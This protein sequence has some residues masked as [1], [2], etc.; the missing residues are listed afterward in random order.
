M[1]RGEERDPPID[2]SVG[3]SPLRPV[4]ADERR[5]LGLGLDSESESN[6]DG[7]VF[8]QAFMYPLKIVHVP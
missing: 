7:R 8:F 4:D 2:V 5:R 3:L 6:G 1:A